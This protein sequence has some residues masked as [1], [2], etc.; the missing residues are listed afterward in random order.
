MVR[1]AVCTEPLA[2]ANVFRN[3]EIIGEFLAHRGA[4]CRWASRR[5]PR[6]APTH[7]PAKTS[8]NV[9]RTRSASPVTPSSNSTCSDRHGASSSTDVLIET[10]T[11]PLGPLL[12]RTVSCTPRASGSPREYRSR[13]P[14][15]GGSTQRVRTQ[16]SRAP[17]AGRGASGSNGGSAARARA[18]CFGSDRVRAS[19]TWRTNTGSAASS[20]ERTAS[21]GRSAIGAENERLKPLKV[22]L[23]RGNDHPRN[24][25]GPTR[26]RRIFTSAP[27]AREASGS[28]AS[29]GSSSSA[30][31][32]LSKG[33]PG[34]GS[35]GT[36]RSRRPRAA[37]AR[38]R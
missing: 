16:C 35:T 18:C 34:A 10:Q 3:N 20:P 1:G 27:G 25:A 7:P 15:H 13:W 24:Q 6:T 37:M 33:S 2:R 23:V 14:S 30:K 32:P 38:A 5:A 4:S 8:R 19:E 12:D 26:A 36:R 9:S 21:S 22:A 28:G 31:R 11:R 17:R 29:A